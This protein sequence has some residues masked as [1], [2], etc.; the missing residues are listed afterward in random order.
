VKRAL[1]VVDMPF[2][3]YQ[4]N[5]EDA[6]RNCGRVMKETYANAVKVEGGENM[7][8]TIR[9]LVDAGMP[10]MGHIG[11][12]PQSVHALA[13]TGAGTR[14]CRGGAAG[15]GCEGAGRCGLLRRGP[16]TAAG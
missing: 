1:L 5:A 9:A 7:A 14:R 2:L 15:E 6:L 12:T 8:P 11:L 3:S 16:G 10:V 4:V 13:A